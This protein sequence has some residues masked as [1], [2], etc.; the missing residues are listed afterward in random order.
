[1]M[2]LIKMSAQFILKSLR[3]RTGL[4]I[5]DQQSH[6]YGSVTFKVELRYLEVN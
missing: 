6:R 1:M 2:L 4:N 5:Y 3:Q